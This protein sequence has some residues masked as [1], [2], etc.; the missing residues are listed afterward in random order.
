M[1]TDSSTP[2]G[3]IQISNSAIASVVAK[4]VLEC[5]GVVGL[6]SK[7]PGCV[8]APE[9]YMKAVQIKEEKNGYNVNVYVCLSYGVKIT[10]IATQIQN[11]VHYVLENTFPI[12]FNKVGV[13]VN[14]LKDNEQ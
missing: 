3:T 10:E 13:Y 8:L 11:K 14:D 2:F 5:Y 6:T 7:D 12:P 1:N 4:A 9:D